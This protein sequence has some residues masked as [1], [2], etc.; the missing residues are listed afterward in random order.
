MD[1]VFPMLVFA[2]LCFR[3]RLETVGA[4]TGWVVFISEQEDGVFIL[5][6]KTCGKAWQIVLR[7]MMDH[8]D[9]IFFLF[10]DLVKYSSMAA[11]A[12]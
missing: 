5:W 4:W 10:L 7:S 6:G 8:K 3:H 1:R 11:L 2:S 9:S 12:D